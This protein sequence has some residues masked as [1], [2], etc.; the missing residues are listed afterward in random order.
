MSD[1]KFRLLWSSGKHATDKPVPDHPSQDSVQ[2]EDRKLV[3][4][5]IPSSSTQRPMLAFQRQLSDPAK[6]QAESVKRLA[7]QTKS[8]IM[9]KSGTKVTTASSSN[10]SGPRMTIPFSLT[11][12]YVPIL[13]ETDKP[14]VLKLEGIKILNPSDGE[15]STGT[16]LVQNKESR[17]PTISTQKMPSTI[18][19][20]P[21]DVIDSSRK[22]NL[23]NSANIK[24][25]MKSS[26]DFKN[27]LIINSDKQIQNMGDKI[28]S[29]MSS[30][31]LD[32]PKTS[33]PIILHTRMSDHATPKLIRIER[34]PSGADRES[35]SFI[36]LSSII[37]QKNTEVL[38]LL[39]I[40]TLLALITIGI[41]QTYIQ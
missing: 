40:N 13:S 2:E 39:V 34:R 19:N 22:L 26:N 5:I 6:P 18:L 16:I 33:Q 24:A 7:D 30:T 35:P 37:A 1:N 17:E 14:G 38:L 31:E 21:S 41:K 11:G 8:V 28:S 27:A 3:P 23:F 12:S 20:I 9:Q 10:A 15:H 32:R 25:A 29:L 4:V 36:P